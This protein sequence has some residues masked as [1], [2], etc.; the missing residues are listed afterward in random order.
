MVDVCVKGGVT[1]YGSLKAISVGKRLKSRH[2]RLGG[3]LGWLLIFV[4]D[5][6]GIT[7]DFLVHVRHWRTSV[8]TNVPEKLFRF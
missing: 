1:G 2:K 6:K 4:E 7:G 3:Q 5:A 8:P